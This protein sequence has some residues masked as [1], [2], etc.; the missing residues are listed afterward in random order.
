M[1]NAISDQARALLLTGRTICARA[2]GAIDGVRRWAAIEPAGDLEAPGQGDASAPP[3]RVFSF[4]TLVRSLDAG[5]DTIRNLSDKRSVLVPPEG[6]F[7]ETI[8]H[9]ADVLTSWGF[10]PADLAQAELDRSYPLWLTSVLLR[11]ARFTD[12]KIPEGPKITDITYALLFSGNKVCVELTPS[13]EELRAWATVEPDRSFN[14]PGAPRFR[15]FSF[16]VKASSIEAG[17]DVVGELTN[18]RQ[19]WICNSNGFD[20]SIADV[21]NVLTSWGADPSGLIRIESDPDYPL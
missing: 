15:A 20:E 12:R 2:P 3:L 16:E 10:D 13:N 17:Y 8:E 4:G 9:A 7:D 21:E 6:T 5:Q 1:K 19:A 14:A 11:T 18:E